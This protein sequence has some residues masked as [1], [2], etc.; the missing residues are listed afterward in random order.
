MHRSKFPRA[1]A[2][3]ALIVVATS[4]LAVAAD[5]PL[6]TLVDQQITAKFSHWKVESTAPCSDADFVRRVYL[7]LTGCIPDSEAARAFISNSAPDKHSKLIDQLLASEDFDRHM[8]V[9]FDVMMM[10]RRPD[11]YVTTPKWRDYLANSFRSNK[12]LD[13]LV[14][15]I[16]AADAIEEPLRSASKFYLD[17]AVDKDTLVRDIGRLFLGVNLQ[18]AQCHDH[19]DISDYLHK[20]YHGLSVFVAGSKIFKQPDGTMVLQEMVMREVAFSSVFAPDEENKTGPRLIES[21]ME[22]PEVVEGE[23]YVEKPSRNV[24]AVPKF[25]L[26]NLLAEKLPSDGTPEFARNMANRLWALMMGRGL[27]HPLDMHHASNPSSHPELLELLAS[28]FRASKFDTK[29]F[30]RELAMTETYRRSSLVAGGV[31][32]QSVAVESY[33]V[34][35]M[36]GLTPEQLYDSLVQATGSQHLIE[37]SIEDALKEDK[38]DYESLLADED[39]LVAARAAK[40]AEQV[41][42]FAT[43]FGG[44]P[45]TPE[46]EFQAS[47]AQALFLANGEL[48]NTWI[49]PDAGNLTQRLVDLKDETKIIEESYLSVLS[50]LPTSDESTIAIEHLSASRDDRRSAILELVWS[51]LASAEFRLNH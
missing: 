12:P 3:C 31:D 34:A 27:V 6:R 43:M 42:T 4:A 24:R 23:E 41:I 25:S 19:P 9:V 13:Q 17:R 36:K 47:L 28:H 39:K 21:L 10:E 26:R 35:I 45:G 32:P 44:P 51:L 18:C 50:R 22:V 20:H 14:R 8:A 15:E 30:L 2:L 49:Q 7:D 48:I 40:K 46:E 33:A 11:K 37:Q 1:L 16:L 29:A 38:E 5:P